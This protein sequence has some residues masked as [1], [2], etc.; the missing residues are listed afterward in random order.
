MRFLTVLT[1]ML[2][3]CGGSTPAPQAAEA[4]AKTYACPMHPNI[5]SDKAGECSKCGMAL[6][7]QEAHDHASH[8]H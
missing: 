3:A 2:G 5:T 4:Q 6:V 7:E 1:L 8:E